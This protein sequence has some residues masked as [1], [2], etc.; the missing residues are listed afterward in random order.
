MD[1][2]SAAAPAEGAP[3][4]ASFFPHPCIKSL[5]TGTAI[6]LTLGSGFHFVSGGLLRAAG[7]STLTPSVVARQ[8]SAAALRIGGVF[9]LF[10]AVRCASE[11]V[12]PSAALPS[13]LAGAAAVAVPTA[14]MPERQQFLR[15]YY[16]SVLKAPKASIGAPLIISSAALSGALT[17]GLGDYFL[18]RMGLRW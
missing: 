6:G 14:I 11:Q 16:A 18:G 5:F 10:T 13:L 2:A 15:A 9:A 4:S 3:P 12:L 8:A 1:A 17:L 7:R